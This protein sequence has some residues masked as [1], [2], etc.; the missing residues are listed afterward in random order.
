MCGIAGFVALQSRPLPSRAVL[1]RMV[2]AVRHRGPDA[3]GVYLD[4]RAA[5]GHRR[6]SIIDLAGGKQ[7]L[8]TPDG[9]VW[10]TFNG[11]IFN[12][13]ELTAELV[14]RG[15]NHPARLCGARAH[16]REDVQRRFR[17]RHLG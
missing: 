15:R 10:V 5:L 16:V 13:V 3:A 11:E 9:N 17:L 6:L 4:E 7:P 2:E 12:Y 1:E 8:S 14:S